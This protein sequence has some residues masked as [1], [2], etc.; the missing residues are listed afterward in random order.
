MKLHHIPTWLG[1]L[2]MYLMFLGFATVVFG[3]GAGI[4]WLI[5]HVR[6]I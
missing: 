6:F 4:N 5:N 1:N 2:M 3:I